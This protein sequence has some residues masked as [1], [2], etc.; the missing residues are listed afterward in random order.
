MSLKRLFD[1]VASLFGLIVLS[2]LLFFCVLWIRYDSKGPIFFRQERVGLY[3]KVFQIHKF[4][5]MVID[6]ENHGLAITVGDDQRITN[7]GQFL[8][9]YKIDE[10]AQLIDVLEGKMSLVGPRPEVQKYVE[11]YPVDV[12]EIVLSVRP[13]I[14]DLASIKY[15]SESEIL[16]KADDPER[17]YIEEVLPEK[18]RYYVDYVRNRSFLGDIQIILKTI[19]VLRG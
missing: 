1:I 16:A 8:R 6:A 10:L 14:T 18:L 15:R 7:S 5:T 17:A 19:G 12:R 3:G 9:H 4:R 2:P 11:F 13:G